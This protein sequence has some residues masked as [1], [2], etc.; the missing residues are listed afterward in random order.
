MR[1]IFFPIP[2]FSGAYS[3]DAD[4]NI[5]SHKSN[6]VLRPN[7]HKSGYLSVMLRED[8]TRSVRIMIH[9]LIAL[10]FLGPCPE[11]FEVD[12]KNRIKSDNSLLNLRYRERSYNMHNV[13]PKK[14][15]TFYK[16]PFKG[17][18]FMRPTLSKPW[19]SRIRY[20]KT[21]HTLG[22]FSTD[23]EAALAYDQ[24]AIAF[25]GSDATTNKSLGLL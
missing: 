5:F 23:K 14:R 20:N 19:M 3:A 4:G 15:T 13:G 7:R 6:R 10:V 12:H 1:S 24:A 21:R 8:Q 9:R 11:G 22:A 25:Y 17:V 2:G 18:V 16:S